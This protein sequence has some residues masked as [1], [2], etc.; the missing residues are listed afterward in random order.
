VTVALT[1][2]R[3][4]HPTRSHPRPQ[5]TGRVLATGMVELLGALSDAGARV[6]SLPVVGAAVAAAREAAG[7][8]LAAAGAAVQ[9]RLDAVAEWGRR[10]V[11]AVQARLHGGRGGGPAPFVTSSSLLAEEE[12]TTT[13]TTTGTAAAE[14]GT[15]LGGPGEG[16]AGTGTLPATPAGGAGEPRRN[17]GQPPS[18][19]D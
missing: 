9:P 3:S 4:P 7:P 11:A 16:E 5:A 10:V 1:S 14:G 18:E 8:T 12:T 17:D 19:F 6:T 13:T 15:P 2:P